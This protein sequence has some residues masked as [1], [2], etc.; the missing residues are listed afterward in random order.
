[1]RSRWFI[2]WTKNFQVFPQ[3]GILKGFL[4]VFGNLQKATIKAVMSVLSSVRNRV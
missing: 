2:I 4:S 1:M 3:P